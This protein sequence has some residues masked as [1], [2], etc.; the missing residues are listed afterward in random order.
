MADYGPDDSFINS[1][2]EIG[3]KS[4]SRQ[5][6]GRPQF[7]FPDIS[8]DSVDRNRLFNALLGAGAGA[9]AGQSGLSPL[10]ALVMGGAAGYAAPRAEDFQARRQ[11]QQNQLTE[12]SLNLSPVDDISPALVKRYPELSGLNLSQVQKIAPLLQR[13]DAFAKELLL[14]REREKSRERVSE[15]REERAVRSEERQLRNE[16]QTKSKDF[17]TIRD[18]YARINEVSKNPSPAGDLS[19]IFS[20]MK[21]LDP[22]SVVRETEFKNAEIA[23]PLMTRLGIDYNKVQ[24]V[25]SGKK[26]TPEQRADFLARSRELYNSQKRIFDQTRSEYRRLA[27]VAGGRPENVDVIGGDEVLTRMARPKGSTGPLKPYISRDGG[28]TWE[29]Q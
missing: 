10:A 17:V 19:M 25:W 22:G 4:Y 12:E 20:Y 6:T 29:P 8:Q 13:E 2:A 9:Q 26:L 24:S 5:R 1:Q 11:A 23:A 21:L 18:N 7:G 28:Q 16:L 15:P 14:I 27:E 3:R